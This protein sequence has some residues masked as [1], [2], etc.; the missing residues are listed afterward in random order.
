[1]PSEAET[2]FFGKRPSAPQTEENCIYP[3][4][5]QTEFLSIYHI[6]LF[7]FLLD[8]HSRF[9]N[10]GRSLLNDYAGRM[11][12][13]VTSSCPFWR[14]DC[15]VGVLIQISGRTQIGKCVAQL[16]M[17]VAVHLKNA[18]MQKGRRFS[19][20]Q[21]KIVFLWVALWHVSS[22]L[23]GCFGRSDTNTDLSPFLHRIELRVRVN[24]NL[25]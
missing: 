10:L 23:A 12:L 7:V 18:F 5:F 6:H 2:Q 22:L 20:I 11:L 3:L 9:P 21:D 25:S 8:F 13:P 19:R 1:M 24:I 15:R 16:L 14:Y 17:V 4:V